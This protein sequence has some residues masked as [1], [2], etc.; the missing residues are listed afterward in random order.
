MTIII[1]A[2]MLNASNTYGF[3]KCRFGSES[4]LKEVATGFFGKQM[5]KSMFQRSTADQ[6]ASTVQTQ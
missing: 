5:L 6:T 1:V 3:V 4:N 2:I